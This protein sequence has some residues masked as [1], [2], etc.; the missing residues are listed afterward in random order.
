MVFGCLLL[1]HHPYIYEQTPVIMY[2]HNIFKRIKKIEHRELCVCLICVYSLRW[3]FYT[4]K[5]T[6]HYN[7]YYYISVRPPLF[8]F[9]K[10]KSM[11]L[12]T[13]KVRVVCVIP[14]HSHALL[15][16]YVK[17]WT[18]C[19]KYETSSQSWSEEIQ[20]YLKELLF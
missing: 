10:S 18:F 1:V 8:H 5:H 16:T 11:R 2:L 9:I 3:I 20:I 17:K 12:E 19:L 15:S 7:T 14:F 4:S 6:Y 13:K